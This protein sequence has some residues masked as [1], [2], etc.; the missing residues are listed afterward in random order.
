MISLLGAMIAALAIASP[1][2]AK[3]PYFTIEVDTTAPGQGEPI[4][5]T[6]RLF[7]DAQHTIRTDWPDRTLSGLFAI[8]PADG[9]AAEARS[10]PV[11]LKQIGPG[12]YVGTVVIDQP[13]RWILRAFPDR[14]SW[15]TTDL[16]AGYPADIVLDVRPRGVDPGLL[17]LTLGA[18][19]AA[20]TAG[21]LLRPK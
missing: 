21:G 6:V 5:L 7:E 19:L 9:V 17:T 12:T 16:P 20:A 8:M 1:A 14:S 2:L 13:G 3:M 15:A 4:T 10:L 11:R 18:A